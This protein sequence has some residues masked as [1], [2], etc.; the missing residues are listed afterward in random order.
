MNHVLLVP[1]GLN[2]ST[3]L[4]LK[5]KVMRS[6]PPKKDTENFLD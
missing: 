6:F 4:S 1:C 3:I 5:P 2:F